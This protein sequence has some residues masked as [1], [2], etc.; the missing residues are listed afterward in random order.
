L[1]RKSI[2]N[3]LPG[4]LWAL[5]ILVLTGLPGNYFPE[6]HSF[7]DWIAPDKMV[8]LFMFGSLTYLLLW[9]LR[10]QYQFTKKR[11]R[12]IIITVV[13]GVLYGG[14]TEILQNVLFVGRDGNIYDFMAN[15]LGGFL[16]IL[17]F[18]LQFR[19]KINLIDKSA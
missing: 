9:G 18:H 17:L 8:H 19:K 12:L 11:I 10:T 15:S 6:I 16:G 3:L 7:W 1:I 2:I 13:V 14:L 4:A 5:A